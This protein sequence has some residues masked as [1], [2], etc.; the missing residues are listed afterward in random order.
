MPTDPRRLRP[1]ELCRLLNSTP[2]GEVMSEHQLKRHRNRAGLR[3][4]DGRHVDLLRYVAWLLHSRHAPKPRGPHRP[5]DLIDVAEAAQG[6]AALSGSLE[7]LKG[8]G[9]KLTSRQEAVIAALLTEPT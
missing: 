8:H 2:L 9:Q 1:A 4:G 3:I 5:P 6:A 7:V